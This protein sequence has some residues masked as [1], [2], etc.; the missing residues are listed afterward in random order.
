MEEA[1]KNSGG[2][3]VNS[4]N[5]QPSDSLVGRELNAAIAE[6]VMGFRRPAPIT[7]PLEYDHLPIRR[8]GWTWIDLRGEWVPISNYSTDI[9]AAMQVVNKMM[10]LGYRYVMRGN[11]RCNQLHHAAFDHASWADENPLYQS[12]L[13]RTLPEA[14]CRAALVAIEANT[15]EREAALIDDC[16]KIAEHE[17]C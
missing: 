5:S 15:P 2:E 13:E 12:R 3:S 9:A 4:L 16:E 17:W 14:I 7:K 11:F 8:N 10:S 1:E 6:R